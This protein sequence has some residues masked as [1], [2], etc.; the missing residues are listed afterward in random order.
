MARGGRYADGRKE[1]NGAGCHQWAHDK[2]V[3]PS[4]T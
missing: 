1:H 3:R 4:K 2:S